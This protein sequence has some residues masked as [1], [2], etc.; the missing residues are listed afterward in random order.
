MKYSVFI[1][2]WVF[3]IKSSQVACY[4]KDTVLKIDDLIMLPR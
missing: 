2:N 4:A 3:L 1:K